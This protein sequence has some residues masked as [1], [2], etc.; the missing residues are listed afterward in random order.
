MDER[1]K[2]KYSKNLMSMKLWDTQ[3]LDWWN[4]YIKYKWIYFTIR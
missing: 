2:T 4:K 1:T 3:E